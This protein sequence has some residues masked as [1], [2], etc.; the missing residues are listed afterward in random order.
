[1]LPF[2]LFFQFGGAFHP[3]RN[4]NETENDIKGAFGFQ[5]Q[6]VESDVVLSIRAMREETYLAELA[7]A[8]YAAAVDGAVL[9][10]PVS[11]RT[12]ARGTAIGEEET[13][14]ALRANLARIERN[15]ELVAAGTWVVMRALVEI[16]ERDLE[17]NRWKGDEVGLDV[18]LQVC[19]PVVHIYCARDA[20]K[21]LADTYHPLATFK[22]LDAYVKA[23]YV[24]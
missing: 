23:R 24:S 9:R 7:W 1:M 21:A 8:G 5:E 20:F 19:G 18:G 13:L 10:L 15:S 14:R 22:A 17:E 4:E 6:A 3:K 16:V 11:L 12:A 2:G